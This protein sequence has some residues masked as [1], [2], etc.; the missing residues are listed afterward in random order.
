MA[1]DISMQESG[2]RRHRLQRLGALLTLDSVSSDE[3]TTQE[4]LVAAEHGGVDKFIVLWVIQSPSLLHVAMS[5]EIDEIVR[6]IVN[7]FPDQLVAGKN[8][9]GDT[10][11][12]LAARAGRGPRD[13][14]PHRPASD[15]GEVE[16]QQAL[17][18][19]R[20]GRGNTPLHEAVMNG[21]LEVVRIL[22]EEDLQP[23]YWEIKE[24]K[25]PMSLA[26]ESGNLEILRI[27]LAVSFDPSRTEGV[28]PV[29]AT[30]LHGKVGC[31]YSFHESQYHP[32][33]R[34]K[35]TRN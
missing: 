5:L 23:M 31:F 17:V 4:L 27:S 15:V 34:Y 32:F 10:A 35:M 20:N 1:V 14:S 19:E 28:L 26:V 18:Q 21:H 7:H 6:A 11:L 30:V 29:H 12:H 16:M 33:A 2:L 3:T 8:C 24:G 9:C 22:I 25:C 13:S